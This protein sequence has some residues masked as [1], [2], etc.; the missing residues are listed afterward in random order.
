M[1][2]QLDPN[3]YEA[4][5]SYNEWLDE[6]YSEQSGGT[7]DIRGYQPRPSFV[8]FTMSPDTYEAAFSDFTQEREEGIKESVCNQFPSPIAYYFYRFENG[9]ESDLQR[10]HLLRDTWESVID[11]LHALAVAECRHRNIQV[12]DPLRFKDLFTDSIA[13]RLENIERITNQLSAEG[14]SPSVAKISPAATLAAMKELNQSR[15]AFSHSA[16]QSE[17]Q[18][19]N[20]ISD[21][22]V[23]VVEVLADL[24]GLEDIQIVRYLSQVDGTT[25]RCEI[26]RGHSST[27]T[28]QNIKI[29]HQQ[30]LDS[31]EKY[32]RP[33]QMLVIADGLIFG[34][35]PMICFREDGV[36]HTT[37]LC[38][39]RKTRGEAP[40][41]RLEYEIIGE[42]V[43][44]EEDRNN[45]AIE[46]N[47]LRSLFGLEE[48]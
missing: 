43:R 17:A 7:L 39:F 25:L 11:I 27:R 36:G 18:A 9:Y 23:D 10:L 37:R 35:R 40:N 14:I 20:W 42:A 8:L 15:N 30:M 3:N 29:S 28:I 26:F 24:D 45:F 38:I 6:Q 31:A 4:C 33:G 21:A 41:R 12:A 13:K 19:R 46:I 48:E 22:Y 5:P 16:A 2:L 34:L 47:E 1:K 44:H 32:F